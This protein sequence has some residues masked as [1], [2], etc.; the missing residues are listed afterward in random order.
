MG[1]VLNQPGP[2]QCE[3]PRQ[4]GAAAAATYAMSDNVFDINY[5]VAGEVTYSETNHRA[6]FGNSASVVSVA[7]LITGYGYGNRA[8]E[9]E[10][11]VL[12]GGSQLVGLRPSLTQNTTATQ[13]GQ[14]TNDIG[15][16]STDDLDINGV[17]VTSL[18]TY[19]AGDKIGFI[20]RASL[21]TVEIFKN[22]TSL[23]TA[24]GISGDMTPAAQGL[25]SNTSSIRVSTAWS[26]TLP[27]DVLYWR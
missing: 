21:G 7:R 17:T 18:V 22:G 6:T 27:G 12:A 24:T 15:Y 2:L 25:N 3:R 5:T 1:A 16:R 13:L 14:G 23:Y 9:F 4:A 26:Y 20:Y 11:M 8:I 19:T 10:S